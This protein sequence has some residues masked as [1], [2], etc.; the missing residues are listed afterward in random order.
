MAKNTYLSGEE[1]QK[2][3]ELYE[4]GMSTK[5]IT[6]QTGR[7]YCTICNEIKK[8]YGNKSSR[9]TIIVPTKQE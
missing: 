1:R 9:Q 2:I 5:L 3:Y 8:K 7:A 4:Q 6:Q